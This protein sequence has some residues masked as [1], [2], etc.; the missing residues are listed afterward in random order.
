MDSRAGHKRTSFLD[1]YSGYH[2]IPLFGPDQENTA[3]INTSGLYC[4]KVILF[5]IKN[6][7]ETYQRLVT[8]I[9]RDHIGKFME[10]YIDDKLVKSR[11]KGDHISSIPLFKSLNVIK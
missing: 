5:G 7:W 3:F 8:K 2:Q 11:K 4:Y 6:A 1:A 10:V 9:F